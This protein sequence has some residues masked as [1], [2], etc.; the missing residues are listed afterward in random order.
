MKRQ[1]LN[2]SN[3]SLLP[4]ELASSIYRKGGLIMCIA[5]DCHLG[6]LYPSSSFVI[7]LMGNHEDVIPLSSTTASPFEK[8]E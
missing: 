2:N 1:T 7:A 5:V 3:S 6:E 8:Y 4:K